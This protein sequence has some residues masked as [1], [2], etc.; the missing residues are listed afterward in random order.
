M[1]KIIFI[2]LCFPLLIFSQTSG[3]PDAYG[4]T[5]IDSNNPNGPIYNWINIETLDNQVSG[6]GDDNIIGSFPINNFSYYWYNLSSISIG[7]NG[8]FVI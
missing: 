7:S 1:K 8:L 4:Y 6:L 3:G 2:L 5:W